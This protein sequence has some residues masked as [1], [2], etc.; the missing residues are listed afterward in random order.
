MPDVILFAD[1]LEKEWCLWTSL[2]GE[3]QAITVVV[4]RYLDS[5][6][7][8]VRVMRVENPI[9]LTSSPVFEL[10]DTDEA[11]LGECIR[12]AEAKSLQFGLK[13]GISEGFRFCQAFDPDRAH[14]SSELDRRLDLFLQKYPGWHVQRMETEIYGS[15]RTQSNKIQCAVIL[16]MEGSTQT[17]FLLMAEF[18]PDAQI[19]V[20][21]RWKA[22]CSWVKKRARKLGASY[23]DIYFVD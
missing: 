4:I 14:V 23:E 8:A 22:V 16:G 20:D 18:L 21:G 13:Y 1:K 17:V 12:W 10:Y 3:A 19:G 2:L 6:A 9:S 5:P 15:C 7:L 11:T